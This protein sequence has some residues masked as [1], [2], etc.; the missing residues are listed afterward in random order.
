MVPAGKY[1]GGAKFTH[2]SH[3]AFSLLALDAKG[4]LMHCLLCALGKLAWTSEGR[5]CTAPTRVL[6]L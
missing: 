6:S 2:A 5:P 1:Q 4:F 3:K